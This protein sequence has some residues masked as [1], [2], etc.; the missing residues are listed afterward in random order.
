MEREKMVF[1]V[2]SGKAGDC[3]ECRLEKSLSNVI[4]AKAGIQAGKSYAT[5]PGF[6]PSQE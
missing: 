2:F 5:P 3:E 4:P 6:L 1:R